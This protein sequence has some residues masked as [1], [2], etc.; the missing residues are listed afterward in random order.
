M[1]SCAKALLANVS[2]QQSDIAIGIEGDGSITINNGK[3]SDGQLV[4]LLT[5]AQQANGEVTVIIK[6]A[7]T[8]SVNRLT[9]IM[10]SCR[11]AGLKKF[12]LQSRQ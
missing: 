1:D 12:S 8:T 11:K 5:Q 7:E 9:F 3:V 4:P 2:I 6:A 10:D